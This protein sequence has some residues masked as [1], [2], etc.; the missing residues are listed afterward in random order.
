MSKKMYLILE[1]GKIF[2]GEN[3]GVCKEMFGEV[4]FTT[5]MTG[6]LETLTDPGNFGQIIVQTFPL[7]GN[8][9]II[10][11]DF[12]SDKSYLNGYIVRNWCQEPSNFR[13]EGF[14]DTFLMQQNIVGVS[15][16]D[17]RA[18]TKVIRNHGRMLGGITDSMPS[19]L[20]EFIEKIKSHK[21]TDAIKSVSSSEIK[22]ISSDKPLKTVAVYDF[23]VKN[24]V[25]KELTSRGINVIK[26]PYNTKATDVLN[27]KIDGIV[28]SNGPSNPNDN[29]EIIEQIKILATSGKPIL[30][31]NLGHQLL[32]LSQGGTVSELLFGHRGESVPIKSLKEGS[33]YQTAQ[34]HDYYVVDGST[35]NAT[36]TYINAN[37]NTNEGLAYDFPA[38]SVQF[39]PEGG[40]G[41]LDANFIYDDFMQLLK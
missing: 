9:G 29:P 30:A 7:I 3:F 25:I 40:A 5:S 22:N 16:I 19:N 2:E 35:P 6:Y 32:A 31:L 20:D 1:N 15:G 12:E 26:V 33:I 36:T 27:M 34:N 41:S 21:T 13:N 4:V 17:T 23:G 28:L 11:S 8:Y 24:G 10:P 18:L 37:D 39:C 14:I 38:I